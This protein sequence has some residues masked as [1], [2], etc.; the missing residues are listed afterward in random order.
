[1]TSQPD[2]PQV[3]KVLIADTW[4]LDAHPWLKRRYPNAS[5]HQLGPAYGLHPHGHMV[6]ETL[7][8]RYGQAPIDIWLY[9]YLE[10]Q[11]REPRGWLDQAIDL[12]IRLINAS[13][14]SD[15]RGDQVVPRDKDMRGHLAF[16]AS[17]NS[18]IS[19]D[20][21]PDLQWDVNEPQRSLVH[22]DG[23]MIIGSCGP[24]AR[25]S[26][27]SSDGLVDAA[28]Q[29]GRVLVYN[30]LTGRREYVQGTSFA[31][32]KATADAARLDIRTEEQMEAYWAAHATSHPAW[33]QGMLSPKIGRG[34]M[35]DDLP[36][37]QLAAPL[38]Y[39]DFQPVCQP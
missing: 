23:V 35:S 26:S 33:P 7:L 5:F 19:L 36:T 12:D 2:N 15:F 30:P 22:N 37:E 18:D 3:P 1:M 6:A 9:A 4:S 24:D 28:Y 34:F 25:P 38:T 17:G 16:F 14:G 10:V 29:G 20:Q 8:Q 11:Q 27:W 21:R 31:A 13:F 32:P 39:L